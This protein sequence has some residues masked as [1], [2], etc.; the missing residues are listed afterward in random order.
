M[1]LELHNQRKFLDDKLFIKQALYNKEIENKRQQYKLN[2]R[3]EDNE[4][5]LGVASVSENIEKFKADFYKQL[6]KI[7]K[8][9][10]INSCREVTDDLHHM[11]YIYDQMINLDELR[12]DYKYKYMYSNLN[13][14]KKKIIKERKDNV[15]NTSSIKDF[16]QKYKN[17]QLDVID[18]LD[19]SQKRFDEKVIEIEDLIKKLKINKYKKINNKDNYLYNKLKFNKYNKNN[20]FLND[21]K[22]DLD[23]KN[24]NIKIDYNKNIQ[25]LRMNENKKGNFYFNEK[26][27]K[28]IDNM[29]ELPLPSINNKYISNLQNNEL[30]KY[31]K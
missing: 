22:S 16:C 2:N 25:N 23:N 5:Q 19:T 3:K 31:K 10:K 27:S 7:V 13:K 12:Q 18:K 15:E 14:N 30:N 9:F 28:L 21:I 11:R 17:I 8:L 24:L 1:Y 26:E 6:S 20:E 4:I 29:K